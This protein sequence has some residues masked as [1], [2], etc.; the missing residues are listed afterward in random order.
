LRLRASSF[1]T[2]AL[3]ASKIALIIV[4]DFIQ[5]KALQFS[6]KAAKK[7][8]FGS[9]FPYFELAFAPEAQKAGNCFRIAKKSVP[10]F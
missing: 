5:A 4:Y 10:Y 6:I 2:S 3:M 7:Q 9:F 8:D 1:W